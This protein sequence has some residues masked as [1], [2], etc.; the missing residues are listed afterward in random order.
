[1]KKI[2]L[3]FSL[4]SFITFSLTNCSDTPESETP[5]VKKKTDPDPDP[6]TGSGTDTQNK[7]AYME[8]DSPTANQLTVTEQSSYTY[9]L[10]TTGTDP[11]VQLKA[12]SKSLTSTQCVLTFEYS[13]SAAVGFI[14]VFFATPVSEERSLKDK[15]LDAASSWKTYSLDLT[16]ERTKFAWGSTGQFLRLDF[17]DVSGIDI[18]IRNICFRERNE[19]EKQAAAEKENKQL[20]EENYERQTAERIPQQKFFRRYNRDKRLRKQGNG[21]RQLQR[22]IIQYAALRGETLAKHH[23]NDVLHR[24]GAHADNLLCRNRPLRQ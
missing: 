11:Y 16:D 5:I 4:L 1:M 23:R 24:N 7:S 6:D 13:A 22:V 2:I 17:G 8:I 3:I 10:R 9:K 14:Q 20:A 21:Q 18:N 12:L 19:A 15:G